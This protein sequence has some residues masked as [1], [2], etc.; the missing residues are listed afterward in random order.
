MDNSTLTHTQTHTHAHTHTHTHPHTHT[1]TRTHTHTHV[2]SDLLAHG[3]RLWVWL[4]LCSPS[5]CHRRMVSA[6]SCPKPL[7][8]SAISG[9]K[10][11]SPLAI[12]AQHLEPLSSS[13]PKRPQLHTRAP[14]PLSPSAISTPKPSNPCRKRL[15]H[16]I[17][18]RRAFNTHLPEIHKKKQRKTRKEQLLFDS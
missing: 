11:L 3:P 9:P 5:I 17:A 6:I 4:P 10:P 16:Q 14:Q 12:S 7:N 18:L 1:H 13:A 8:P 15:A 2:T